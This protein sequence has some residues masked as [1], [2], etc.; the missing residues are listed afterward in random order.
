MKR[1]FPSKMENRASP[2]GV[3]VVEKVNYCQNENL[4][5]TILTF[6]ADYLSA[7]PNYIIPDAL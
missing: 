7:V 4:L 1:E 2:F 6:D 5:L 3:K